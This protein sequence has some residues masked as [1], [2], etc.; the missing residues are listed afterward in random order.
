MGESDS[1][2][3]EFGKYALVRHELRAGAIDDD[4][5]ALAEELEV[6]KELGLKNQAE[7]TMEKAIKHDI[8]E[9]TSSKDYFE[10]TPAILRKLF[11]I[12]SL[13]RK[14][15][16]YNIKS[17][18]RGFLVAGV[19]PLSLH[20]LMLA[21]IYPMIEFSGW[22]WPAVF[23]NSTSLLVLLATS[24]VLLW[25]GMLV[26]L[27][28]GFATWS[29]KRIHHSVLKIDLEMQTLQSVQESIP[30][31]AKLKVLEASKTGIFNNFVFAKPKFEAKN[32][33]HE[34]RFPSV[35]PAI[36]G[37]TSDKRMYMIVYWDLDK[38]VEKVI[39]K[40]NHFKKFKL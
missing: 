40:I 10:V 20:A 27:I 9:L 31:G 22:V 39:K 21:L 13:Q 34:V 38:D 35:D 1:S 37:N 11:K 32:L 3:V 5:K 36:L 28:F 15:F 25:I 18:I 2:L 33:E 29:G 4:I 26:L 23:K 8:D 7:I 19:L 30:Y 17:A 14:C 16:W 24:N 12:G 6:D